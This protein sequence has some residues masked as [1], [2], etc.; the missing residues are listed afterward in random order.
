MISAVPIYL[1]LLS[2]CFIERL[3]WVDAQVKRAVDQSGILI[4]DTVELALWL[5]LA[6]DLWLEAGSRL[7]LLLL[8]LRILLLVRRRNLSN[9]E[10]E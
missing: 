1:L 2:L 10:V 8:F 5:R 4:S 6:G 7:L 9:A 3:C